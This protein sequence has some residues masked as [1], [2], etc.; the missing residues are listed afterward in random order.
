MPELTKDGWLALKPKIE[1][2]E[3][4]EAGEGFFAYLAEMDALSVF[5]FMAD[6]RELGKKGADAEVDPK[7]LTAINRTLERA[8][9]DAD[10]NRRFAD[11]EFAAVRVPLD[12]RQR[13]LDK[14]L[15]LSGLKVNPDQA[16]AKNSEPTRTSVSRVA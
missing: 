1:K 16:D 4:P 12:V 2:I 14:V 7:Q 6:F 5:E 15:E 13:M 11:G 10:G 9:V 8:I 3:I